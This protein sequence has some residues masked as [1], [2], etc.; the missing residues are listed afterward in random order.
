MTSKSEKYPQLSLYSNTRVSTLNLETSHRLTANHDA[1][2]TL[3]QRLG[4]QEWGSSIQTVREKKLWWTVEE[5][6]GHLQEGGYARPSQLPIPQVPPSPAILKFQCSGPARHTYLG[7]EQV[8]KS[9]FVLD[10]NQVICIPGTNLIKI[11]SWF[12]FV[13][14]LKLISC[15]N[16][17]L[18]HADCSRSV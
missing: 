6:T 8:A 11:N 4:T 10:K 3:T 13:S 18:K 14:K 15:V 2:T 17:T 9:W 16:S 12:P 1:A 7:L 5:N